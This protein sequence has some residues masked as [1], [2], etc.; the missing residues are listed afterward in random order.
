[1]Q[2]LIIAPAKVIADTIT[3]AYCA[4]VATTPYKV[5]ITDELTTRI[6]AVAAWA[7][8]DSAK[9]GLVLHSQNP[10][11]GKTTMARALFRVISD[12]S[13]G[14][15]EM[16][17]QTATQEIREQLEAL[18]PS[19]NYNPD[20]AIARDCYSPE[21]REAARPLWEK[22]LAIQDTARG[23]WLGYDCAYKDA[24]FHSAIEL[25]L[26]AQNGGREALLDAH[27]AP[28]KA[29]L[30]FIDDLGVEPRSVRHYGRNAYGDYCNEEIMPLA[31]LIV[32]RYEH[33]LP[34]IITTNF[35]TDVIAKLYGVRVVD[36]LREMC[37]FGNFAGESYR[38]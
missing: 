10:G 16:Y 38:I 13:C 6:D 2:Q 29:P 26:I 17:L 21:D 34:V 7:T 32:Y 24:K 28:G 27:N 14:A 9:A 4:E 11:T 18:L 23:D 31:E 33:K 22:Y 19:C 3:A 1:M 37:E 30:L 12:F 15:V 35:A 36:R 20:D 5:V 25:A 8:S